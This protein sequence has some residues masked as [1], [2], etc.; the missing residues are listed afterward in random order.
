[1]DGFELFWMENLCNNI[2]L[3]SVLI[4]APIIGPALFAFYINDLPNDV[5]CN[6]AS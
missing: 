6:I 3:M 4:K 1:M 2:Q 5:Y